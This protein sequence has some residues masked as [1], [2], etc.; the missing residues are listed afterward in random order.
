MS[1]YYLQQ[2]ENIINTAFQVWAESHFSKMSLS[3]VAEALSLSKAALYR[4]FKNKD[5]LLQTMIQQFSQSMYLAVEEFQKTAHADTLADAVG[6]YYTF[7]F[8]YFFNH[9]YYY[10]FVI[11]FILHRMTEFSKKLFRERDRI[12]AFFHQVMDK[13]MYP[14]DEYTRHITT[15]FIQ[16]NG[17]FWTMQLF[18]KKE[19]GSLPEYLDFHR[20]I[21]EKEMK[22]LLQKAVFVGCN[23]YCSI[24]SDSV[25]A[26]EKIIKECWISPEEMLETDRIF[27][28]VEEVV[29]EVGFADA[30]VERIAERIGINKS[31]LYFYFKNKNEMFFKTI[32]REQ[33]HLIGLIVGK[34]SRIRSFEEKMFGFF[35]A[36]VSQMLNKP[37][38]MT[39]IHWLRKQNIGVNFQKKNMGNVFERLDF[40]REGIEQGKFHT[41]N[42]EPGSV[43]L[44]IFFFLM[45]EIRF[46]SKNENNNT[47]YIKKAFSLYC[48]GIN[49]NKMKKNPIN[50]QGVQN[51]QGN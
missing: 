38:L 30:S 5:E 42:G 37:Y 35:I 10:S 49:H 34:L 19:S 40:L 18:S 44:F 9:P 4:Y 3:P 2:R 23:G 50:I 29:A 6:Q 45:N 39:I 13:E 11:F 33:D 48:R 32:K 26:Y 36:L 7:L 47:E 12:N 51:E 8:N 20:K 28:A 16:L 17:F 41:H 43:L 15:R 21:N 46:L 25:I 1:D 27:S 24:S 22:N 31:S 14:R